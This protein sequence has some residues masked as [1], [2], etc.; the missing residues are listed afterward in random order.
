MEADLNQTKEPKNPGLLRETTR[1]N[2]IW[3]S[4]SPRTFRSRRVL[5]NTST[6]HGCPDV[7]PTLVF[8]PSIK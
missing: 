4:P 6:Y 1:I 8:P 3:K 2:R 7:L 5:S